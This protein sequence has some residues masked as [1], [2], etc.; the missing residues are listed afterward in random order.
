MLN[1]SDNYNVANFYHKGTIQPSFRSNIQ[2]SYDI[3]TRTTVTKNATCFFRGDINW[4]QFC[5]L[6]LKTFKNSEKANIV[7]V[8]C[9]DGSE[10]V[11]LLLKLMQ[12]KEYRN[13]PEKFKQ[14]KAYDIDEK[15]LEIAKSNK[16]PLL[17]D[18]SEL[19]MDNISLFFNARKGAGK[20][21]FI[22]DNC[23]ELADHL[24]DKIKY[25][26]GEI[27]EVV[28]NLPK[29]EKVVL[30]ARN[31]FPYLDDFFCFPRVMNAL[32][33]LK[34][35]S[36]LAIGD[37]DTAKIPQLEKMIEEKGYKK[38]KTKDCFIKL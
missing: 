3:F 4:K 21:Y 10:P 12:F 24:K 36:V 11:S 14:I 8:P 19:V 26:K 30:L 22:K 6:I 38:A 29:D 34:S 7:C 13:K 33:K 2:K 20:N 15:Q 31:V 35:G 23:L 37:Y 16:I 1:I 25:E 18:L 27:S 9:S 32:S 17:N 5:K 28:A